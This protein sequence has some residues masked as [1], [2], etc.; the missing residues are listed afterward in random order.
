MLT[1]LSLRQLVMVIITGLTRCQLWKLTVAQADTRT[2]LST[3]IEQRAAIIRPQQSVSRRKRAPQRQRKNESIQFVSNLH[4]SSSGPPSSR[5]PGPRSANIGF[6]CLQT[7][8][9]QTGAPWGVQRQLWPF[10]RSHTARAATGKSF[11]ENQ[12]HS[13]ITANPRHS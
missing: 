8:L 10:S 2:F 5:Y 1:A 12:W 4:L 7:S 13:L 6:V 3:L 9:G 11:L